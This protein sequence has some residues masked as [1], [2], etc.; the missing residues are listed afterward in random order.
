MNIRQRRTVLI[1]I[2]LITVSLAAFLALRGFQQ[3][4][5]YYRTPTQVLMETDHARRLRVGGMVET[6]SVV[7]GD[8]MSVRFRLTDTENTI[9]VL[10]YGQLPDLFREGQGVVVEGYVDAQY[11]LKADLLLAKHDEKYMPPEA[12]RAMKAAQEARE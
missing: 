11:T 3:S 10:Y 1:L 5:S 2:I 9:D 7:H 4:V 12:A 6:G 8:D